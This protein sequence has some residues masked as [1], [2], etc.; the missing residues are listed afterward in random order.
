VTMLP[1][2]PE[3][4]RRVKRLEQGTHLKEEG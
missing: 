3:L 4:F 2:L 1:S